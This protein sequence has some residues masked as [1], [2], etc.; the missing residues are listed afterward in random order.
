MAEASAERGQLAGFGSWE[1]A[2]GRPGGDADRR[3]IALEDLDRQ[4]VVAV[5]RRSVGNQ[6][7]SLTHT[8]PCPLWTP[9]H[10]QRERRALPNQAI[11]S[12]V[13]V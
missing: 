5:L 4:H 10:R 2:R 12:G 13:T 11:E 3:E 9:E 1:Q 6:L 7:S 8:A